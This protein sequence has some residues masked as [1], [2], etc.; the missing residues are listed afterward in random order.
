MKFDKTQFDKKLNK[1]GRNI[2][3]KSMSDFYN[4]NDFEKFRFG[5]VGV[6]IT[7]KKNIP[8]KFLSSAIND[9]IK[10][11]S[12]TL[13]VYYNKNSWNIQMGVHPKANSNIDLSSV[14]E[15]FKDKFSNVDVI[16][17][18]KVASILKV[19]SNKQAEEVVN[20]II[21]VF[22]DVNLNVED[23]IDENF[24]TQESKK[25]SI[26]D[27][28]SKNVDKHSYDKFMRAI[29]SLEG[30]YLSDDDKRILNKI[31]KRLVSE[32]IITE[33]GKKFIS[34]LMKEHLSE[35]E[36]ISIAIKSLYNN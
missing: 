9:G 30:Q 33:K 11:S 27:E 36:R 26:P 28:Y 12:W 13:K 8:F 21:R 5:N 15:K 32:K 25:F 34:D 17:H 24:N 22:K 29:K 4:L 18:T 19:D 20:S 16:G 1:T 7:S 23:D 35:H 10:P 6:F 3:E 31:K 14:L 2:N